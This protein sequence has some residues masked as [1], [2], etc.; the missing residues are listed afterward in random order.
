METRR[1][2]EHLDAWHRNNANFARQIDD[3]NRLIEQLR[4]ALARL[5]FKVRTTGSVAGRDD[6]LWVALEQAEQLLVQTT[7]A[8]PGELDLEERRRLAAAESAA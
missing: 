7:P 4:G 2:V 1:F 8:N 5:V 6:A 3:Q